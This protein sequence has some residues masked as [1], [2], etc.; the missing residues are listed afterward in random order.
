MTINVKKVMDRE[1]SGIDFIFPA[2]WVYVV[3]SMVKRRIQDL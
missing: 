2:L 1:A 3:A